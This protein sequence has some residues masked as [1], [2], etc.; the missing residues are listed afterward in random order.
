MKKYFFK[1]FLLTLL[2]AII[3]LLIQNASMYFMY[4]HIRNKWSEEI[5]QACISELENNL[6]QSTFPDMKIDGLHLFDSISKDK[7]ISGYLVRDNNG[8]VVLT[9]GQTPKGKVLA[10]F[11]SPEAKITSGTDIRS[12]RKFTVLKV[13]FNK[14]TQTVETTRS[15]A[16]KTVSSIF[17]PQDIKAT[18]ILGSIEIS[19]QNTTILTVDI[20]THSPRTFA[21]TKQVINYFIGN[22]KVI[23]PVCLLIA[24]IGA[25]LVSSKNTKYINQI[26]IALNDLSNGK[27]EV[28]LPS[29]VDNELNEITQAI[30]EL[31]KSLI[32]NKKS[33]NAWLNSI[34]HD[35]NTPASAIKMLADGMVDGI[36]NADS[37][38]LQELQKE[39]D[40]L[41]KR[42]ERVVEYSTLIADTKTN[43]CPVD[44]EQ[45]VKTATLGYDSVITNIETP[46]I[47]CDCALII[48]AIRELLNNCQTQPILTIKSTETQNI[49]TVEN[50]ATLSQETLCS[51]LLEPWT[52]GDYS[53]TSGGNGLGLPIVGAIARL[54]NGSASLFQKDDTVVAEIIMPRV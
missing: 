29:D 26:R 42:I 9:V 41:V 24:L 46:S 45:L 38:T 31:D 3:T 27:T 39:S 23:L 10:S 12:K 40:T 50:T 7:R 16:I 4:R 51:D 47:N 54:H 44:C 5:Y 15:K 48:R 25:W 28:N 43:I 49:I 14:E 35:L 11:M 36:F 32:A 37:Q 53:R 1:Y 6:K 8:S 52:R 33:R 2:I 22:L 17:V 30:H 18:D 19:Y 13:D 21:Y 34:S 20:L